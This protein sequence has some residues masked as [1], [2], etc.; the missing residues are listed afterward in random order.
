MEN[1]LP[2]FTRIDASGTAQL[3]HL[4]WDPATSLRHK[5][6]DKFPFGGH[7]AS[8]VRPR[9]PPPKPAASVDVSA[10]L[11]GVASP[12]PLGHR[13]RG[14]PKRGLVG[15][16]HE[17]KKAEDPPPAPDGATL[18]VVNDSGS[19]DAALYLSRDTKAR[20]IRI[21][22]LPRGGRRTVHLESGALEEA[23]SADHAA[24]VTVAIT[25]LARVFA[26][27]D[28]R[29]VGSVESDETVDFFSAPVKVSG[30][31]T[32]VFEPRGPL[33]MELEHDK[34]TNVIIIHRLHPGCQAY[35][36]GKVRE[37][38]RLLSINGRSVH[39]L[40]EFEQTLTPLKKAG[41]E[42]AIEFE[43][44]AA[45]EAKDGTFLTGVA[46]DGS[47]GALAARIR[48]ED[49]APKPLLGAHLTALLLPPPS[50]TPRRVLVQVHNATPRTALLRCADG[51]RGRF[52]TRATIEPNGAAVEAASTGEHWLV[53]FSADEGRD[54]PALAFRVGPGAIL[55]THG[56]SLIWQSKASTLSFVPQARIADQ[57]DRKV[58]RDARTADHRARLAA[59]DEVRGARAKFDGR[60]NC[61]ITLLG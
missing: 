61:A 35:D 24:D 7:A 41:L 6:T 51:P 18:R 31:T 34:A 59:M 33:G 3:N 25:T 58:V 43:D 12:T 28:E 29:T 54:G 22:N 44:A 8:P 11:L 52:A 16:C 19:E 5:P 1:Y 21:V 56:Y 26:D 47:G 10:H 55:C 23:E 38:M 27:D 17:E 14:S 40:D 9:P 49:S 60:A 53:T 4:H 57:I 36:S 2:E 42:I 39:N 13:A 32:V 48:P 30:T 50:E 37:G 45:A 20:G 15:R 46:D